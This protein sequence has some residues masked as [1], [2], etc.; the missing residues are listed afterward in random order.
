MLLLLLLLLLLQTRLAYVEL[1][2]S[3]CISVLL[4][5][6]MFV[7]RYTHTKEM[8]RPLKAIVLIPGKP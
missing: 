6:L 4:T 5:Y 7:F 2:L 1:L 8:T 3:T